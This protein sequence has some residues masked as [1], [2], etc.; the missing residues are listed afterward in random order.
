[1]GQSVPVPEMSQL[2]KYCNQIH[3]TTLL[4]CSLSRAMNSSA[5]HKLGILV[6]QTF[7]L[8]HIFFPLSSLS[9]IQ[10][11]QLF[12]FL[13]LLILIYPSTLHLSLHQALTQHLY[14]NFY[15][16]CPPLNQLLF[17]HVFHATRFVY[18][19]K[20]AIHMKIT[21]FS[22]ECPRKYIGRS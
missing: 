13:P 15:S 9:L 19:L 6:F 14:L 1:M 7:T 17:L 22:A 16:S 11:S 5:G 8:Y 21:L 10:S 3:I 20:V 12:S 2:F 18:P 4:P